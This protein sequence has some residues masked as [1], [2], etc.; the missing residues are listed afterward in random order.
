M[1]YAALDFEVGNGNLLSACSVGLSVFRDFQLVRRF[2]SLIRP[3]FSAGAFHWGNVR[4]HGIRRNDV[5]HAP[6]FDE[7]WPSLRDDI[8]GSVIVCHNASF[9]TSVLCAILDHFHLPYPNCRYLC[10]VKI[11]QA[12][13][14]DME[15]HRLN[16]LAEALG[17]TLEHHAAD[18]D[19]YAAGLLLLASLRETGCDDADA[20]AS[21]LGLRLGVLGGKPCA[22]AL[23][24]EK[25]S[26]PPKHRYPRRHSKK[27]PPA[28]T[29]PA[30]QPEI[31]SKGDE[32][33]E[34]LSDRPAKH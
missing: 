16:T 3:P 11:S 27:Q 30:V 28:G 22:T 1:K 18:S 7:L 8:E 26:Q 17:I 13:W 21:H 2:G 33:Y 25:E 5:E 23:E 32:P 9:D 29:A 20:L 15:N 31:S 12:V 10:T 34:K 4:V 14:P 24:I 19:A 6:L